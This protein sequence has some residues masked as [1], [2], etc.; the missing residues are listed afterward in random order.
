MNSFLPIGLMVFAIIF[1]VILL[2]VRNKNK[3]NEYDERQKQVKGVAARIAFAFMVIWTIA[4]LFADDNWGDKFNSLVLFAGGVFIGIIIY[5][6]YCVFKDG[7]FPIGTSPTRFIVISAVIGIVNMIG[8][9]RMIP[10]FNIWKD[11]VLESGFINLCCGVTFIY[12]TA[13]LL[14]KSYLDKKEAAQ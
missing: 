8:A 9:V 14:V 3:S 7:Y 11:A 1:V 6:T 5:M 2:A 4:A 10:E 13:I 12:F